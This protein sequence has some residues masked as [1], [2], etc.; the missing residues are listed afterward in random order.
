MS[1][2]LKVALQPTQI[3]HLSDHQTR[4]TQKARA[5]AFFITIKQ[6]AV[7]G[8]KKKDSLKNT[9]MYNEKNS[10]AKHLLDINVNQITS[11]ATQQSACF[12]FLSFQPIFCPSQLWDQ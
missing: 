3:T 9:F 1:L 10:C 6:F 8:K 5:F 2:N 11:D 12:S 4:I 7:V